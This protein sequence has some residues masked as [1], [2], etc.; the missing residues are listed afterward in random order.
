MHRETCLLARKQ[1]V[2][3]N[4][5]STLNVA[6]SRDNKVITV[7]TRA[8]PAG[9][10]NVIFLFNARHFDLVVRFNYAIAKQKTYFEGCPN[11]R[12]TNLCVSDR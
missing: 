6:S 1:V 9:L 11:S 4:P 2:D 3:D 10:T 5:I 12:V 8:L 7:V